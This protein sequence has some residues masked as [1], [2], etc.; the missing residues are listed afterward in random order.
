MLIEIPTTI[1][2]SFIAIEQLTMNMLKLTSH[3]S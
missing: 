2:M 1:Y 3:P